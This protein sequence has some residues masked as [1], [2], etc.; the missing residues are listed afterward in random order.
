M[1]IS[2]ALGLAAL[3]SAFA[4][5]GLAYAMPAANAFHTGPNHTAQGYLGIDV[6][7]VSEESVGSL[8]L[9]E[10][11]GAE[12]IRV[13]HDG[14]AGKMG[15]REHDVVLQMNG[16]QIEGEEPMRRLLHD[17]APGKTVTLL[18]SRDGQQMT[19][20]AQM[21]DRSQVEKQA[22]EQ[23]LAAPEPQ[24]PESA[25][26]SGDLAFATGGGNSAAAPTSRYSK[27]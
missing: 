19:V 20:T 21:A 6:R 18:I 16:I 13:D 14:P 8:H 22:F 24:A 4:L 11:R 12:I 27:R 2:Y 3:A 10:A 15:L 1:R 5:T 26:P 7:D 17:T 25:L 23:H 9:R